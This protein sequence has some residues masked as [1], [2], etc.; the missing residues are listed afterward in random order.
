MVAHA[1]PSPLN[2]DAAINQRIE[3]QTIADAARVVTVESL[4][5]F[6][7][8]R[9]AVATLSTLAKAMPFSKDRAVLLDACVSLTGYRWIG[10]LTV[11]RMGL[12]RALPATD[13][14]I[15]EAIG[16]TWEAIGDV[17]RDMDQGEPVRGRRAAVKVTTSIQVGV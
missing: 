9:G 3:R 7:A 8:L 2:L 11:L 16:A 13:G 4:D 14:A 5:S 1:S 12:K 17:E 6:P 15:V 10:D